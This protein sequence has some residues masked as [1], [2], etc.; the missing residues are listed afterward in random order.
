MVVGRVFNDFPY[1][2]KFVIYI[3]ILGGNEEPEARLC[4]RVFS[5]L[6]GTHVNGL[7][8]SPYVLYRFAFNFS[9]CVY[10]YCIATIRLVLSTLLS[11][12]FDCTPRPSTGRRWEL[13]SIAAFPAWFFLVNDL[14]IYLYCSGKLSKAVF[15]YFQG[16]CLV[17]WKGPIKDFFIYKGELKNFWVFLC[18]LCLV[19]LWA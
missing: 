12:L 17:K 9:Y 8:M 18:G 5:P 2:N 3:R 7:L 6:S 15:G 16:L 14:L 1:R 11:L 4:R 10:V 19:C 13:Y